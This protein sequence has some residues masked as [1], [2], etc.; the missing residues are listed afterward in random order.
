MVDEEVHIKIAGEDAL[1]AP[2]AKGKEEMKRLKDEVAAAARKLDDYTLSAIAAGRASDGLA[3]K[4]KL[5]TGR[6]MELKGATA[7][8]DGDILQARRKF[9]DLSL[10]LQ[11]SELA[12]KKTTTGIKGLGE[13]FKS[14]LSVGK[15]AA[16]ASLIQP[17]AAALSSVGA[18]G[19]AAVAGLTPLLSLGAAL[20]SA[21]LTGATALG[22]L[23]FGLQG[24]G[25]A[26]AAV[27]NPNT[28][29]AA[30]AAAFHGLS[31]AARTLAVQLGLLEKGPMQDLQAAITTGLL[32]GL[33]SLLTAVQGFIPVIQPILVGTATAISGIAD[34]A[35][36]LMANPLFTGQLTRVMSNNNAVIGIAGGVILNLAQAG[37]AILDAFRPVFLLMAQAALHVSDY[38]NSLAQAGD[39]S[40]RM[41]AFFM[42][43]WKLAENVWGVISNL[44]HAFYNIGKDAMGLAGVMGGGIGGAIQQFR[45]WTDS[46]G[47]ENAIHKWFTDAEP[48]LRS[49]GNL[50]LAVVHAFGTL[51]NGNGAG[52]GA[53][54]VMSGLAT[55]ING[56]ATVINGANF[57]PFLTVLTGIISA[58]NTVGGMFAHA[59]PVVKAAME[60]LAGVGLV[61][62]AAAG[63]G[64]AGGLMGLSDTADGLATK[65]MDFHDALSTI[66]DMGVGFMDKLKGHT[67]ELADAAGNESTGVVGAFKKIGSTV[68]TMVTTV[69]RKLGIMKAATVDVQLEADRTALSEATIG[70]RAT[71]S[72]AEVELASAGEVAANARVGASALGAGAA[73]G[74]G[75]VGAAASG[76]KLTGIIGGLTRVLGGIPG[77]VLAIGFAVG[78]AQEWLNKT[79]VPK[80][81]QHTVQ[82]FLDDT[83]AGIIAHPKRVITNLKSNVKNSW[84]KLF[85]GGTKK[86]GAAAT[87]PA[88]GSAA[89][90]FMSGG[91]SSEAGGGAMYAP[92]TADDKKKLN[93]NFKNLNQ[94]GITTLQPM[95]LLSQKIPALAVGGMVAAGMTALFGEQGP[96]AFVSN[97]GSVSIIGANGPTV[98][99]FHSAGLVLPA[100]VL[101]AAHAAN[102]PLSDVADA[103]TYPSHAGANLSHGPTTYVESAINLGGIHLA[104]ATNASPGEIARL[105]AKEIARMQRERAERGHQWVGPGRVR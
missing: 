74:A 76:G 41:T 98:D 31:P 43:A 47:G 10:A 37:L 90:P 18:G 19:V 105:A 22:V 64:A 96:E 67:S 21:M 79:V 13:S 24:V 49:V 48:V 102:I 53:S 28:S 80:S 71:A 14:L 15:F 84:D 101:E 39:A 17:A 94:A 29:P 93:N 5:S 88:G 73:G 95:N 81:L 8:M 86:V 40:G 104:N 83:P 61:A 50:V 4:V 91:S 54:G 16:I 72:A 7:A 58:I 85:G 45:D 70:T 99:T 30:M 63:T 77:L 59:N 66:K 1:S 100:P 60:Q 3:K 12:A 42:S 97:A 20:P 23:K 89:N 35:S 46:L 68:T 32:P 26:A 52:K 56:L 38:I 36:A 44:G 75:L 55:L 11:R 62:A 69:L 2:L 6:T 87:L 57:G 65:F 34:S 51:A 92:M 33:S 9:D 27:M 82:N 78:R 25:A 103:V